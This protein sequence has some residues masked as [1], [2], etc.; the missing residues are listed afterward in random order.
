V[1]APAPVTWQ[2]TDV[3]TTTL[4]TRFTQLWKQLTAQAPDIHPVRTRIFNLVA[5]AQDRSQAQA[6]LRC[7]DSLPQ[8]H[9]SRTIVLQSDRL[10]SRSGVDAA[11]TLTCDR[12][13]DGAPPGCHERVVLQV[14]GRAADHLSSVVA[15]LLL[16]ELPTYLWWPG[17]PLFGHRVFHRLLGVAENLL[18]D[19]AQF[20]NPGDGIA[21]LANLVGG[22]HAVNDTNWA[23]LTPWRD[24]VA[25]FFDAPD[26]RPHARSITAL[27]IEFGQGAGDSSRATASV[28]LMLGW[29]ASQLG[30]TPET[31]LDQPVSGDV[32]LA[33]LDGER[34]IPVELTV[35]DH[36][37]K[38]GCRLMGLTLQSEPTGL[39][40]ASFTVRRSADLER[41]TVVTAVEGSDPVRR[42]I[43]LTVED[44]S[45]LVAEELEVVG[46]DKLYETVVR[47]ASQMAGREVW[48]VA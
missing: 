43:P 11:L 10:A 35:R 15:P 5:Y 33:V 39:S 13:S 14:H 41:L 28:L 40:R 37:P 27:S 22:R 9:P 47:M 42:V 48:T 26:L 16:A 29:V 38:A 44:E 46:R 18:V 21:D 3:D 2:G 7:L 6:I 24:V 36:G 25:Q 8:V 12:G 34:V 30:W 17:Q 32:S 20:D 4:E 45:T 23:R 19:S 31:T 1:D